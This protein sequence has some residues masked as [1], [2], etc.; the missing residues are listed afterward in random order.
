MAE[1]LNLPNKEGQNIQNNALTQIASALIGKADTITYAI[2]QINIAT[3]ASNTAT[4]S[5]NSKIV[6]VESRFQ[7]LT[8][9]QQLDAEVITARQGSPSLS[10][11]LTTVKTNVSQNTSNISNLQA[12]TG[13]TASDIYGIEVDIQ[14]NIITRLA[15]AVGKVGGEDFNV[16][17]V[18]N[19]RRC[20]LTNDRVVLAYHG[21]TG[22]VETGLTTVEI[23]KNTVVYPIGTKVQ[24]MV[25]QPIFYYKR[26]P[27]K[28]EK[29]ANGIGFHLR[30]WRDYVCDTPKYGFKVHP[31][32][33]RNGIEYPCIYYYAFEASIYDKSAVS[34]LL[35]DEQVA[36]FTV[37][38]GDMLSSIASAKPCSG[39]TQDLTRANSRI[40]A[41]NRGTGWQQLD[42]LAISAEQMLS[43]IEYASFD[44]QTKIGLGVINKA[45]GT[46]NESEI[47]GGTSYLGNASG[48]AV[49]TN[50]LVSVS[51]RG[52]ENPWGNIWKWLDGKN[53]EAKNIHNVFIAD[54]NFADNINTAPYKNC[55]FT[56]AKVNGY[57]SAIGYSE[58][59][60][61]GFLPSE[62]LG[63][64]NRPINDYFYQNVSYNG[65]LVGR[66]GGYWN[67][68]ATAGL[69]FLSAHYASSDRFR[70]IGSGLLCIPKL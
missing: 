37:T 21:E 56:L 5:A 13:Y 18:Y 24:V 43:S 7:T 41:N 3:V 1:F 27:L 60:D 70:S 32:F 47:T 12:Y 35:A 31:N 59:F 50:G 45:S 38:T 29:I 40:L 36:D 63:A 10:A 66:S 33:V 4:A 30:K 42:A 67:D 53:I 6:D 61:F 26:I 49:G 44:L 14:N 54:A 51:Y 65:F 62:A 34:Y 15:G 8:A 39:L 23:T 48:M 17:N 64:S 68:S 19:R 9:Q 22:Y 52:R 28:L 58:F 69:C 2:N 46:G 25:E 20:V 57:I 16:V 11:N 55:N